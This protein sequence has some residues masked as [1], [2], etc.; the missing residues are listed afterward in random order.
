L[1]TEDQQAEDQSNID[2]LYSL[3]APIKMTGT[4]DGFYPE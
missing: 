2:T 4:D 1:E 3:K